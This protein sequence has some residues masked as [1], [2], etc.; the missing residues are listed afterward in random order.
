[1]NVCK[2]HYKFGLIV[3]AMKLTMLSHRCKRKRIFTYLKIVSYYFLT[4]FIVSRHFF[5]DKMVLSNRQI[6]L[7][8]KK[9]FN[10]KFFIE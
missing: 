2:P 5:C 6:I 3:A 9:N 4:K 10:F 7:L 8:K 1:M